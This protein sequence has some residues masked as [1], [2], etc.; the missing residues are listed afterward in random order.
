MFFPVDYLLR[1]RFAVQEN[2]GTAG[3]F[4]GSLVYNVLLLK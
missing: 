4:V 2:R 3:I 1:K